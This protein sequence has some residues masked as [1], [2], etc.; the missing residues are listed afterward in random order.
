M[1]STVCVA[2]FRAMSLMLQVRL[3]L[4]PF[5]LCIALFVLY[6]TCLLSST[7]IVDYVFCGYIEDSCAHFLTFLAEYLDELKL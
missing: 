3:V 5:L 1:I 4:L 6:P 2:A 7:S